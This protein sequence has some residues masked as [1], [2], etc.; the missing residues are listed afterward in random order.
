MITFVI[1][2]DG[3]CSYK[4]FNEVYDDTSRCRTI[5]GVDESFFS[6]SEIEGEKRDNLVIMESMLM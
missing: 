1:N 5:C 4:L 6:Y 3:I 2:C